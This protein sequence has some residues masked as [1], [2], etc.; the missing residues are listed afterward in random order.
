MY[1]WFLGNKE[2]VVRSKSVARIC[3]KMLI[4][5]NH[6]NLLLLLPRQTNKNKGRL[7]KKS[8]VIGMVLQCILIL[9]CPKLQNLQIEWIN[10]M[11]RN[12]M[13]KILAVCHQSHCHSIQ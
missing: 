12:N 7:L 1:P 4:I 3:L 2:R 11:G 13:D 8:M 10:V 9:E 5:S 6:E